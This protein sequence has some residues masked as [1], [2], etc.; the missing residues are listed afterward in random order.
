[1]KS[2]FVD[3]RR[4]T[5]YG[6]FKFGLVHGDLSLRNLMVDNNGTENEEGGGRGEGKENKEN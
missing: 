4:K 5:E 6:K 2:V 3:L 1:M